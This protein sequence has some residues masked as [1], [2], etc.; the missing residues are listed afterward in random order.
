MLYEQ[1]FPLQ[2]RT[3]F[4]NWVKLKLTSYSNPEKPTINWYS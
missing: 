2:N 3:V 1:T 4:K